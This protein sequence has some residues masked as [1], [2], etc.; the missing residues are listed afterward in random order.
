MF[1]VAEVKRRERRKNPPA[2]FTTST[3]QQEA[4]K[5]LGFGSKRTMRIAQDLYEGIELGAEGAVGL[6]TYMRTDST[7]VSEDAAT[8]ARTY[9]RT[10][11]G[12]EY[13]AAGAA[14]VR[15]AARQN[16]QDAHEGVR[17]T[18]PTR[19]PE[20]VQKYLTRRPVQALPAR[21]AALHGVAD[22]AGRVRH[23]D[24]R[25]RP[26][27][28][29]RSRT[30]TLFRSTGSIMKFQGFLALYRE[31]REEGDHKALEDE[32]ALPVLE[33]GEDVPVQRSRRRSTS[34]SRR[35]ASP[36][37]AREGAGA[38]GHRPPVDVRVIISTLADRRYVPLEQR[39]F[40]PTPL[41]ETVEKVMVKKFPDIFNVRLHL[42]DGGGARP[43]RGRRA[44]LAHGAQDF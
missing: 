25:L 14:A 10:L 28:R 22:G 3:L 29:R 41:G 36:R 34:P 20:H 12:K 1:P 17:P 11:F 40:F 19:R 7:R 21:L 39:R 27:G 44:A 30:A 42:G 5:K 18:D 8:A 2:P 33:Q 37:R 23:D 13:L 9:L 43:G 35:R 26:R 32:Q 16:A 24:H 4:A 6:I 31:A 38:P 15:R